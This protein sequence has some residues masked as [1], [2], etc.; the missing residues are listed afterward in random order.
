MTRT[1]IIIYIIRSCCLTYRFRLTLFSLRSNINN[2]AGP[3]NCN[4]DRAFSLKFAPAFIMV[5]SVIG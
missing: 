5:I 3:K 2:L 1:L 4:S